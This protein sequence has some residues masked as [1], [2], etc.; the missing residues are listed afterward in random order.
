MYTFTIMVVSSAMQDKSI[1]YV[2]VVRENYY[3]DMSECTYPKI[4]LIF[5]SNRD[6]NKI[7]E[8]EKMC[9]DVF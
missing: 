5:L 1:C 2:K 9:E 7:T 8:I 4:H 3:C 6:Y